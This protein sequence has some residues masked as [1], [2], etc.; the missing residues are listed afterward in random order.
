MKPSP[1]EALQKVRSSTGRVTR[2]LFGAA[3]LLLIAEIF[4]LIS[5]DRHIY[6][7]FFDWGWGFY[8]ALGF[9][10]ALLLVF[11]CGG[12]G[13]LLRR[14]EIPTNEPLPEDLDER[15]R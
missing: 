10:G 11:V 14:E 9:F 15:L 6:F 4:L 12:L 1:K 13:K 2:I 8:A 7:P 3:V 5:H